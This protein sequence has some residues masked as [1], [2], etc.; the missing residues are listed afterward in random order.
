MWR[1][2]TLK[3]NGQGV[4]VDAAGMP[5]PAGA[6]PVVLSDKGVIGVRLRSYEGLAV[7]PTLRVRPGE[8]LR[9]LLSAPTLAER[10]ACVR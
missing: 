4:L 3:T 1:P 8:T 7:G 2:D 6:D 10:S 9:V 5:L